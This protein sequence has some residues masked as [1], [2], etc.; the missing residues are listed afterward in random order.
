MILLLSLLLELLCATANAQHD[1]TSN[2]NGWADVYECSMHEED[3]SARCPLYTVE[4]VFN[5]VI[6]GYRVSATWYP[7][8]A[9]HG[10]TGPAI[11]RLTSVKDRRSHIFNTNYFSIPVEVLPKECLNEDLL[12]TSFIDGKRFELTYPLILN[13][14]YDTASMDTSELPFFFRDVDFDKSE[15]LVFVIP[16][17][18][19]R[20]SN[21]YH[22]YSMKC[23][24]PHEMIDV[25]HM[26]DGPGA[27][28]NG[29]AT[30]DDKKKTLT[31]HGSSSAM[32]FSDVLYQW[33]PLYPDDPE[34]S[35]GDLRPASMIAN[36]QGTNGKIYT[37]KYKYVPARWKI[38][39]KVR[40]W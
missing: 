34:C 13:N 38:I 36:E 25:H 30:F 18:G 28:F 6:N 33:Q 3:S 22:S 27:S 40:A 16:W 4:I 32:V 14:H 7:S 12:V 15:E 19:E 5:N 37:V 23:H 21:V 2:P 17:G 29:M 10:I 31:R 39:S 1:L 20:F 24:C 26:I 35:H 11:V 9:Y 8:Q